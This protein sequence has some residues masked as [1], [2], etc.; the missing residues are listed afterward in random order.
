M[1]EQCER[2][3]QPCEFF[4]RFQGNLDVLKDCWI[5]GYCDNFEKSETCE[6]KKI[7]KK[8]GALPSDNVTPTGK[9]IEENDGLLNNLLE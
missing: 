1:S 9:M 7:Y 2:P 5:E 3:K 6:R 8:T 4:D